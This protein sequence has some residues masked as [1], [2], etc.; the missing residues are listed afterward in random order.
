MQSIFHEIRI[1]LFQSLLCH[2]ELT[3]NQRLACKD[4]SN[5][6]ISHI[7]LTV[8]CA[9]GDC[10]DCGYK[11]EKRH[12]NCLWCDISR[13]QSPMGWIPTH[14]LIEP[15]RTEILKH[16][17][18]AHSY[19]ERAFISFGITTKMYLPS[20]IHIWCLIYIWHW[21]RDLIW[22]EVSL[23][24]VWYEN[25]VKKVAEVNDW[26]QNS[27]RSSFYVDFLPCGKLYNNDKY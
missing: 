11:I 27:C 22:K 23:S 7:L 25:L 16:N 4:I 13:T 3:I 9:P 2:K 12:V 17:S 20:V 19:D 18:P 1:S 26:S 24:L 5:V 21:H 8:M 6:Q 14:E 15:S 10:R